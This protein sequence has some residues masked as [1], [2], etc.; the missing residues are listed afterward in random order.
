MG[1]TIQGP[2]RSIKQKY[3]IFQKHLSHIRKKKSSDTELKSGCQETHLAVAFLFLRTNT[4]TGKITREGEDPKN[5]S[6][7][8]N[9]HVTLPEHHDTIPSIGTK[10]L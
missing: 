3:R 8:E 4:H 10:R 9:D 2:I 7:K 1:F 5:V 6:S